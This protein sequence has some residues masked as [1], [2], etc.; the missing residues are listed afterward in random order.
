MHASVVDH[1][2]EKKNE[3]INPYFLKNRKIFRC[4]RT[5]AANRS[6][7]AAANNISRPFKN[8][9]LKSDKI[10][11]LLDKLPNVTAT[12]VTRARGAPNNALNRNYIYIYIY[13]KV[14]KTQNFET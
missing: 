9:N 10:V 8:N 13:A 11:R 5:C 14:R 2:A 4:R 6:S 12:L 3:T 1:V 7:S